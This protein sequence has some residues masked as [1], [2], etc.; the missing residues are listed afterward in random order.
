MFPTD[1]PLKPGCWSGSTQ[2]ANSEIGSREGYLGNTLPSGSKLGLW[3]NFFLVCTMH[4]LFHNNQRKND[5]PLSVLIHH[6]QEYVD[7]IVLFLLSRLYTIQTYTPSS[8]SLCRFDSSILCRLP[9][10]LSLNR[11]S[12]D[13]APRS[14]VITEVDRESGAGLFSGVENADTNPRSK[15][16]SASLRDRV[17]YSVLF[18]ISLNVYLFLSSSSRLSSWV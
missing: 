1:R 15:W 10:S 13:C 16:C 14:S 7:M 2:T 8:S 4:I 18:T 6:Q 12:G 3:R 17:R 5:R 9:A 11:L